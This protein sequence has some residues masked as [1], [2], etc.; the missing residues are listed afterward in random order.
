MLLVVTKKPVRLRV[1]KDLRM[2]GGAYIMLMI[3]LAYYIIFHY[4]PMFGAVIAFKD[5]KPRLGIWAVSGLAGRTL[6][7]S[8]HPIIS[9]D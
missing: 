8:F 2:Y 3:V 5:F 1:K 7:A 4:T 6:R 9:G